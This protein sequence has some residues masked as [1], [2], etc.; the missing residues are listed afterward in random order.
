VTDLQGDQYA[1]N[2]F[3]A[4]AIQPDNTTV[5]T[6]NTKESVD[7]K[8]HLYAKRIPGDGSLSNPN[9]E[10]SD[11]SYSSWNYSPISIAM[12]SNGNFA[13]SWSTGY[14][15]VLARYFSADGTQLSPE[16]TVYQLSNSFG[17]YP[18]SS[19]GLPNGVF[20]IN[21]GVITQGMRTEVGLRLYATRALNPII[22]ECSLTI[23][24]RGAKTIVTENDISVF[25]PNG[26]SASVKITPN[27]C[28]HGAFV[29]CATDHPLDNFLQGQFSNGEVCHQQD[30][31]NYPPTCT[32]TAEND[33]GLTDG[34]KDITFY[35]INP[36]D[37]ITINQEAPNILGIVD[38]TTRTD[39]T[40]VFL[41]DD[42]LR[43]WIERVDGRKLNAWITLLEHL[44]TDKKEVQ[45]T[46]EAGTQTT[47]FYL[48]AEKTDRVTDT[49]LTAKSVFQLIMDSPDIADGT[50]LWKILTPVF[51]TAF[52]LSG[53][54]GICLLS[55]ICTFLATNT[56]F[57]ARHKYSA[58]SAR[59]SA[60]KQDYLAFNVFKNIGEPNDCADFSSDEGLLFIDMIRSILKTAQL[61]EPTRTEARKIKSLARNIAAAIKESFNMH[62]YHPTLRNI[63]GSQASII[64]CG[65]FHPGST[66]D[67]LKTHENEIADKLNVLTDETLSAELQE[68]RTNSSSF[69]TDVNAG[70]LANDPLAEIT[71]ERIQKAVS[72]FFTQALQQTEQNTNP[73]NYFRLPEESEKDLEILNL[74]A[75]Q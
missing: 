36:N 75:P 66:G 59:N 73:T 23:N 53:S 52:G 48:M 69:T 38:K 58:R 41:S 56:A 2:I 12:L 54:S 6:W 57:I 4:A 37:P 18:I 15:L 39:V 40:N 16:L 43:M 7:N 3:T 50:P 25:N 29:N 30:G 32:I 34:P 71:D 47:T 19:V 67:F 68:I 17:I 62:H 9:I 33:V 45:C 5:L 60:R 51:S 27:D 72:Q 21:W 22:R 28:E 44:S 31:T 42:S 74:S 8:Y 46:P 35:F 49:N 65:F 1:Q 26:S 70:L 61:K 11:H 63:V 55:L 13:I 14:K 10:V 64:S 20:A 24:G